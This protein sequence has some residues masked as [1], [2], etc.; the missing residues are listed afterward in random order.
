MP[1]E[2]AARRR[3]S[4]FIM[5]SSIDISSCS[6]SSDASDLFRQTMCSARFMRVLA[7]CTQDHDVNSRS[8]S[9]VISDVKSGKLLLTRRSDEEHVSPTC[10][11]RVVGV[12]PMSC[13]L[14]TL[15]RITKRLLAI[16]ID[17]IHCFGRDNFLILPRY[18]SRNF[19]TPIRSLASAVLPSAY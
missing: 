7:V 5:V 14:A 16:Q 15:S 19:A 18:A 3:D 8:S 10:P 9:S 12:Q 1:D 11:N 17:W 6:H 2:Y 4:N 13:V